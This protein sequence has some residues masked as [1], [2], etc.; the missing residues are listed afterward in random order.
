MTD[1]P[2]ELGGINHLA[3]VCRDMERTVAFYE[4]VLGM[5][6]V[7][8]IELPA[9]MGQHFFFDCGGSDHLAFFWFP[10]AAEPV[11]GI[12]GP[13]VRPDQGSLTSAIGSM[14]HVAFQVP[15]EKMEEYQAKLRAA[16][17]ET[18]EIANH[19]DSEWTISDDWTDD[20]YVRSLYFV[21][22]DGILLEFAAW[23]RP[24]GPADVV[25]QPNGAV[26]PAPAT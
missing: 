15:P 8:T 22:P 19:D 17:V 18:S 4:G 1:K 2:F 13:G 10:D 16:G 20:V 23:T 11:S 14:N 26:R 3:L 24:M 6:L 5:P 12:S 25:H 21:D 7:K 9:G